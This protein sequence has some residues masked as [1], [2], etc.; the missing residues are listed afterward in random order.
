MNTE[1]GGKIKFHYGFYGAIKFIYEAV[2]A[3]YSFL[4]EQQLGDELLRL[5]MLVIRKDEKCLLDDPIGQFFR[6][7]NIL[8]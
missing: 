7:H 8:D 2:R 4:Q 1:E 5:D 6:K 3:S